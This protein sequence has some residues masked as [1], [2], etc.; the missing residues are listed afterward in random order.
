MDGAGGMH[1]ATGEKNVTKIMMEN[2][3]NDK[4]DNDRMIIKYKP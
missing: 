3:D 1:R 2:N 4:N